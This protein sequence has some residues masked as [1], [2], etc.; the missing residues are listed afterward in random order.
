MVGRI[1]L[2]QLESD[3]D[4]GSSS[5]YRDVRNTVHASAWTRAVRGAGGRYD[6]PRLRQPPTPLKQHF[7][8][9]QFLPKTRKVTQP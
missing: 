8:Q 1:S 5:S 2:R 3:R 7:R 6:P 9:P 4:V